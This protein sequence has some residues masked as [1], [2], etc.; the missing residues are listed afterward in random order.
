MEKANYK[1]AVVPGDGIGPEVVREGLKVLEV[2]CKAEGV[3]Y[4]TATFDIGG[5]RYLRTGETLH[6]SV[7]EELKQFDAIYFGAIGHPDVMPG[8]LERGILLKLRFAL[9]LFVNLRP[10]KLYPGVECPL[11]DKTPDDI[12]FVVIRENTED[13]YALEGAAFQPNTENEVA[14]QPAIYTR[15]GT[16]RI[17][18]YAFEL[19]SKRAL[20]RGKPAKV[21]LVDKAN[22]MTVG[23]GLW[24]RVFEELAK[25]FPEVETEALYVDAAAMEF[26]LHP[27]RFQVVVTTNLFGDI[28]TDLGAA[29]QGGIGIAP[30]GNIHPGKVSMFE[31]VHGSAPSIAGKGLACPLAAILTAALMMEHLGEAKVAQ[32]IENAVAKALQTGKIRSL[33]AGKMGM[34]T[35]EVGDL[36]AS[37]V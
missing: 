5:E 14:I 30:S 9:D 18:R 31:P 15:R 28:L 36:V 35:Q 11:K 3:D 32:R 13:V 37:L 22:V 29:I 6:D 34:S 21:T 25:E 7:L 10:V 27:E 26:V 16:E 2:A 12:D 8:V 17:I 1:I 24:R 33:E 23:H 4:E 20:E 19:A